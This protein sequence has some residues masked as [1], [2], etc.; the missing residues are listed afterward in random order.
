MQRVAGS[1]V[2]GT[3][4][5]VVAK[6]RADEERQSRMERRTMAGSR[7]MVVQGGG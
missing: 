6:Q 3:R 1:T 5:R 4:W 7:T 2:N